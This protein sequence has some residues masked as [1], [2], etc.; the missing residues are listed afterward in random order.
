LENI[1]LE[2]ERVIRDAKLGLILEAAREVFSH[3]GFHESRLEDIAA[4]AGFS[5]ASLYNYFADKETIFLTLAIREIDLLLDALRAEFIADRQVLENIRSFSTTLFKFLSRYF[6]FFHAIMN[7]RTF[8]EDYLPG[9]F[10][11]HKNMCIEFRQKFNSI[12]ELC[13]TILNN[14]IDRG[15]FHPAFEPKVLS[16]YVM[17]L[18]RGLMF[19]WTTQGTFGEL[20]REIDNLVHF[21]ASGLDIRT[22]DAEMINGYRRSTGNIE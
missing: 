9:N 15:D 19:H 5:K 22:G 16:V 2:R 20:E 21:L 13:E 17:S 12:F 4:K 3:T 6:P 10:I 8:S 14:G 18:I 11:N 1:K 7:L